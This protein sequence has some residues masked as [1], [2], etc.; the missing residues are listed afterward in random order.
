MRGYRVADVVKDSSSEVTRFAQNRVFERLA[1]AGYVTSGVLHLIIGYLAIRIGS[2]TGRGDADASGALA[3]I[4]GQRGGDVA[5]WVAA[6]AFGL[7][8]AWRLVETALGRSTD[9]KA[10]SEVAEAS[11]RGKALALA[12]VYFGFAYSA[13][14]FAH[15]AGQS[16]AA[17]TSTMSARLMQSRPGTVALIAA[18]VVVVAVGGY[19]VYKGVSRS[20]LDDLK[21]E[22]G[23]LVVWLGVLGYAAKGLTI[24]GA[25][26]LVVVAAST[27][28]PQE[29][30]GLDGA[31]KTLGA[32][33]YGVALLMLAAVGLIVYGLYSFVMARSMKM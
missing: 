32:Q 10:Q 12:A 33:P 3:T 17:Q 22:P 24:A 25:G 7:M 20:F 11:D 14:G 8:G 19:H 4:A 6:V 31:L 2:G 5:L 9:P 1:R 16:S 15:G 27:A 18:G 21:G 26:I 29:A 28:K 23:R 13:F 30:T